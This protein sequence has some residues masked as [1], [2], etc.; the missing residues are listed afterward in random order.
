MCKLKRVGCCCC[1]YEPALVSHARLHC[2]TSDNDERAI[3]VTHCELLLLRGMGW[4]AP[5]HLQEKS[6]VSWSAMLMVCSTE[7]GW[8]CALPQH[9]LLSSFLAGSI[10]RGKTFGYFLFLFVLR[11]LNGEVM[12]SNKA[13]PIEWSMLT[14]RPP[15]SLPDH[16][17]PSASPVGTGL[18]LSTC[19]AWQGVRPSFPPK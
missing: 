6:A 10:P 15:S 13:N 12:F 3:S 1:G 14:R 17:D 7:Q 18:H 16:A 4:A 19:W 2:S 8:E 11:P 5:H 9:L